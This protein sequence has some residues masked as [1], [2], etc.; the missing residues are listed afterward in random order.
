M[1]SFLLKIFLFTASLLLAFLMADFTFFL[2]MKVP[3]E[4]VPELVAGLKV[5]ISRGNAYVA[6]NQVVFFCFIH[7]IIFM[8]YYV[9]HFSYV[10]VKAGVLPSGGFTCRDPIPQLSVKGTHFDK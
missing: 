2:F 3:F 6:M 9:L 4:E 7:A 1:S 8:L 5:Y 10:L